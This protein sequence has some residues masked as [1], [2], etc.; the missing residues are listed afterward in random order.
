M[1]CFT[2]PPLAD[3]LDNI[4]QPLFEV[5]VHPEKDPKLHQ[6]LA[7]VVGFDCVD[8]ES[9]RD[10]VKDASITQPSGPC[11]LRK[12]GCTLVMLIGGSVWP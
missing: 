5:S 2:L 12:A 9:V 1:P 11:T 10:A 8:D 7:Q 3:M 4:F 6:F